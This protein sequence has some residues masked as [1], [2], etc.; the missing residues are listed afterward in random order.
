MSPSPPPPERGRY[1]PRVGNVRPS[2]LLYSA[3][4]GSVVELPAI[5]VLVRGLDAWDY[6]R[7]IPATVHEER[8]LAGVR[9]VLGPQVAELREPPVLDDGFDPTGQSDRV[10]VPVIPFPQWLR[11]TAC[12]RLGPLT[13]GALWT[14]VNRIRGRPDR[15]QFVHSQC[16]S[17]LRDPIAVPAR[18]VLA[19]PAGHLDE[20]PWVSFV[21][22]GKACPNGPGGRLRM[23]DKAGSVGPNVMISCECGRSR[24]MLQAV[25][26]VAAPR[27][28]R[29]RGRHP[30][31]GRFDAE[32]PHAAEVRTLVLG[33]SNQW[34]AA[35]MSA[36]HLPSDRQGLAFE[37]ERLWPTLSAVGSREVLDFALTMQQA[38]VALRPYPAESVWEAIKAHRDALT[39]GRSE[40][41]SDLRVAEYQALTHPDGGGDQEDFTAR[42]T[43]VPVPARGLVDQ[44]VLVERL[45]VTSAFIGFTRLDAPEWGIT[46]PE[47]LVPLSNTEPTWVP[48][49]TTRG[50]GIFVRLREDVV[51]PWEQRVSAH[52]HMRALEA[53]FA[54]FR[55]TRGRPPT[56]WPGPRY[57]LL[58]SLSHLLI[59]QMALE[60]G[61]SSA[62]L[63]ERLYW[64]LEGEPGAGILIY[65]AASDSE[66]TLGGLVS[67]GEPERLGL[68]L[69]AALQGAR[70]C[71]SDPLCAERE[72]RDPDEFVHGAACHACLF[73]SET[74]CERGNRFLDRSLVVPLDPW[75]ELAITTARP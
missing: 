18:F 9:R 56:G 26:A 57:L 20:F 74:T 31:L 14:F 42:E 60:C 19:C 10:G 47:N 11:C 37:V 70:W 34:F 21:H 22:H 65:T 68:L 25:G 29:C 7:T 69:E 61:Y 67:L 36:L 51:R 33:A 71:S 13:D 58:H 3:G 35:S 24:N 75:P 1:F 64:D 49:A 15:A 53:A 48:A 54:R 72:P 12:D 63:A 28:P 55:T 23:E 50:E 46:A 66:G 43:S 30:H 8:L 16:P 40:E 52:P 27:L 62:S 32:C 44:V 45:R 6:S 41:P 39:H 5:S 17:R 73:L 38:L 2:H 59:R 4:V